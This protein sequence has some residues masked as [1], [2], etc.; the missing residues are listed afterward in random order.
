MPNFTN[1]LYRHWCTTCNEWMLFTE[2]GKFG[3]EKNALYRM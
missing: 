3:E 1:Y 2:K